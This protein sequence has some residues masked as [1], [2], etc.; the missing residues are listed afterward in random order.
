MAS[1]GELG[2]DIDVARVPL[3]EADME[4]F[5]IMVSESQERMLC[6]V[7]PAREAEVLALCERWELA[8]ARIGTVTD[9]G[10][11]RVLR[12]ER[13]LGDMPVVCARRRLPALRAGARGPAEPLY[14]APR[15]TLDA[16]ASTRD[17]LLA[18]LA[19][20]N[21]ASRRPLFEQYDSIVQSRTVRRPAEA[22]AAVLLL[23]R[24]SALAVSIDCNGRRVAADP[25][26]GAIEAVLEC[27]ANLAC[28][29][30]EPLGTTNNLNFG[31]P[32][33]PHVA[34]QLTEAVRGLG[35]ACRELRAPIVGG[36]VSLYNEGSAGPIY[37]TPVIGMVGRM[38]DA[39]RAGR[40]AFAGE[41]RAIALVGSP[42]PAL[43]A[44]ELE[45]LRG[46]ALPDGL[47][48][49]RHRRCAGRPARG[50]RGGPRGAR[51]L[52][53][54]HRRGRAGRRPRRMLYRR[55]RSV[56]GCASRTP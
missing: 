12:G 14:P 54:R 32:E 50:A 10:R 47:P 55:G 23:A 24:R 20:P 38:P 33:K 18:L 22:D 30:A 11:V 29:G 34:W 45:R 41:D 42:R 5:E 53:A 39:A 28:T 16:G 35:E 46:M 8:A 2:I 15:R 56:P 1:K 51:R 31:N 3:R 25:Y 26:R 13:V 40:L 17:A 43:A 44:G 6:V 4:P 48:H 7:E 9:S 49:D 52:R 37:P 36:N 19:S 21:I 27:A